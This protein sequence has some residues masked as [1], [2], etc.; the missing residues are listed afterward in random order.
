MK[1]LII[2]IL[3][4][5]IL[6][7]L[8]FYFLNRGKEVSL[9]PEIDGIACQ[10]E[11]NKTHFHAHM[12]MLKDGVNLI[13]PADIG[14]RKDLD[15]LYWLHTHESDGI[16]HI[17]TPG[18]ADFTLGQFFDIWGKPLTKT[19]AGDLIAKPSEELRY[20]VDGERYNGDPKKIPLKA[21]GLITI[22]EGKEVPPPTFSFPPGT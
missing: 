20:Y 12:T 8:S 4:T 2:V 9:V 3:F 11:M 19:Q 1:K 5:A 21:H 18:R 15:C 14:I 17:E 22:E 6:I 16:I 10:P 13:L 7:I